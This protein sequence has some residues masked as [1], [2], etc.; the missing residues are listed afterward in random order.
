MIGKL[1]LPA[2][3]SE[4]R[5]ASIN[6]QPSCLETEQNNSVNLNLDQWTS[7]RGNR[8][9]AVSSAALTHISSATL[10]LTTFHLQLQRV[11]DSCHYDHDGPEVSET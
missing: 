6:G 1:H 4:R 8:L 11:T 3:D 2:E 9:D 10:P 5:A 7:G